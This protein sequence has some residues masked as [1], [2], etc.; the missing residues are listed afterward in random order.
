MA[1]KCTL[2][3]RRI[4]R[5][6]SNWLIKDGVMIHKKC[7]ASSKVVND[8]EKKDYNSLRDKL[9]HYAST[10]PRGYLEGT[11]MNFPRA[12]T[13]I[14][15]MHD[16][17]YSYSEIEYALDSVV[18]EQNGFWGIKAVVNRI[19]VIVAKKRERDAKLAEMPKA[20]YSEDCDYMNVDLSH[21]NSIDNDW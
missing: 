9:A 3:G 8:L 11:T 4:L 7:P 20:L 10:C 1:D 13:S 14:K 17:G 18:E 15:E 2:C 16:N 12:M 19:D 21:L 5:T 6:G